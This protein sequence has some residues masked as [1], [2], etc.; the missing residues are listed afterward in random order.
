MDA[1]D[2]VV[3][4]LLSVHAQK[5]RGG[6][7]WSISRQNR[8][9]AKRVASELRRLP[10]RHPRATARMA[11]RLG[12]LEWIDARRK[13]RLD[14]DELRRAARLLIEAENG[15]PDPVVVETDAVWEAR[16]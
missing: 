9:D 12:Q 1:V 16:R 8:E 7:L 4:T 14:A 6:D 10:G 15:N 5:Q 3:D 13:G 11:A 2:G